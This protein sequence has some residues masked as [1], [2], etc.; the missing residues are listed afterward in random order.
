MLPHE[1]SL[2]DHYAKL[3]DEELVKA[4]DRINKG[5]PKASY[6]KTWVIN[7]G[8]KLVPAGP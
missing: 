6:Y 3:I 5:T 7:K 8:E 1:L 2:V 4:N